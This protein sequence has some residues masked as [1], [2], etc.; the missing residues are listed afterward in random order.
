L[1]LA[2]ARKLT[3]AQGG[4]VRAESPPGA[5]ATFILTLPAG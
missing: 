5:E 4:S 1:G 2:I 3:E